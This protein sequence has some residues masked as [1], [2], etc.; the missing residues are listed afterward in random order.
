MLK[1]TAILKASESEM[2]ALKNHAICRKPDQNRLYKIR[3]LQQS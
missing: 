1:G 2:Q 3:K